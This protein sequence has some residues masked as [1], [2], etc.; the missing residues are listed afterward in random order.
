MNDQNQRE[1]PRVWSLCLHAAGCL[2]AFDFLFSKINFFEVPSENAQHMRRCPFL[3]H[4]S[5]LERTRLK[6]D[7]SQVR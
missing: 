7:A 6:S 5:F 3:Q 1:S 4:A 2:V